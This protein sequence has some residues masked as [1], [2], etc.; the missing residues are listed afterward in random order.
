[1]FGAL[2]KVT[3]IRKTRYVLPK[4][5]GIYKWWCQEELLDSFLRQLKKHNA[6]VM[7]DKNYVE[8][9]S[10]EGKTYYCFYVGK[11]DTSLH[12]R[13]KSQHIGKDGKKNPHLG[14]GIKRSTLRKS[15]NALQNGAKVFDENYVD[16]I[17]NQCLVQWEILSAED[18]DK[19]E[20]S[21][22]NSHIRILNRDDFEPLGD[23]SMDSQRLAISVALKEARKL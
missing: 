17:L 2:T 3:D 20:K 13:L 9:I 6:Y 22:I 19:R 15:I 12:K 11:T 23:K 8:V 18:I 21:E 4:T 5:G 1:M 7:L 16:A 10:F 14:R